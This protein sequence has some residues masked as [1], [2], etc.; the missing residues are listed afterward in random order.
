MS[1]RL[2]G[3]DAPELNQTCGTSAVEAG[4]T[5]RAFLMHVVNDKPLKCKFK[6]RDR[7][8]RALMICLNHEQRDVSR[9]MVEAGWAWAYAQFTLDYV[10]YEAAARRQ[11]LGVHGMQCELPS[12]WRQRH[13]RGGSPTPL[14]PQR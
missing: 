9:L 4:R 7:H 6:G 8:G 13:G 14:S 5:A 3:I 2:F 11:S 1:T 12:L 10:E